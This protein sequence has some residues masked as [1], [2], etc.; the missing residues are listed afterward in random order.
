MFFRVLLS[1]DFCLGVER[2]RFWLC[3]QL[4]GLKV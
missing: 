4:D 1:M 3:G 2:G